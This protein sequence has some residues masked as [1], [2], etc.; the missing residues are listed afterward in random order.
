MTFEN[1]LVE[2]DG[3]VRVLTI[4]RPAVLNA[5]NQ[6][7]VAELE[8]AFGDADKDAQAGTLRALII[9]GA[10]EKSFVAG[11]DIT[12]F[13]GLSPEQARAYSALGHR[14]LDLP[15]AMSIPVIAAVNGFALGGGLELALACDFI[16]ASDN[17]RLGLVET[18]LGI[19]PGFGGVGRLRRRVGQAMAAELIF[20]AAMVKADEALRI[21]LANKVV[22]Q[23][24]LLATAKKTA[25]TIAD[26]GPLATAAVKRLLCWGDSMDLRAANAFEATS[27]GMVF[28]T[29]DKAIGVEAFLNKGKAA[30]RGR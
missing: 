28:S 13:N 26:K 7:T 4:N 15:G 25:A 29:E 10:G 16:Y 1:L 17:A 6:K 27:F 30:F 21:G 12:E 14:V 5:L 24:E 19:I 8:Q 11:A 23:A 3:P 18:N 2:D 9:T 22:P 20:S